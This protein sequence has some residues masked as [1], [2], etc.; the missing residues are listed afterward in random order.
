[1]Q[2]NTYQKNYEYGHFSG[3]DS[4]TYVLVCQEEICQSFKQR[5]IFL[6]IFRIPVLQKLFQQLFML[7]VKEYYVKACVTWFWMR[8]TLWID[9]P[10][11]FIYD[12]SPE[13]II[14]YWMDWFLA[15]SIFTLLK[16]KIF[17]WAY[18]LIIYNIS[19]S[20]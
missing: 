5:C 16:F 2:E 13:R 3:S 6:E 9:S 7:Q 20:K 14:R 18:S 19:K 4:S 1:M 10:N 11:A 17:I 8:R 15:H 12:V